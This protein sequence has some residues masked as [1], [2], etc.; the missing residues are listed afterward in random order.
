[1]SFQT[2]LLLATFA[3]PSYG[4]EDDVRIRPKVD[5]A[6]Q[7]GL[8]NWQRILPSELQGQFCSFG[9]S[10]RSF[11]VA[12]V[13]RQGVR[14]E[15]SQPFQP[16][17]LS[18]HIW[19][20]QLR[21]GL[22]GPVERLGGQIKE[23]KLEVAAKFRVQAPIAAAGSQPSLLVCLIMSTF[24]FLHQVGKRRC[25]LWG[26]EDGVKVPNKD[27]DK[28]KGSSKD[29]KVTKAHT[30]GFTSTPGGFCMYGVFLCILCICVYPIRLQHLSHS[31][32]T[33][34]ECASPSLKLKRVLAKEA[35][36]TVHQVNMWMSLQRW[37][38]SPSPSLSS[39]SPSPSPSSSLG[40]SPPLQAARP[41]GRD[42]RA[43]IHSGGYIL[44]CSQ[45]C[46][47]H[48]RRSAQIGY[49][50]WIMAS[51]FKGTFWEGISYSRGCSVTIAKVT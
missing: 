22:R 9:F 14:K 44:R 17:L 16:L 51:V 39:S 21:R 36:L 4:S 23:I 6:V 30:Q 40:R 32:L 50:C 35:G 46:T 1:M 42:H 37:S 26:G 3:Q 11:V 28:D 24:E 15:G 25:R 20:E 45:L 47:S 43:M 27:K 19:G 7:C 49:L 12:I 38:P 48:L 13:E 5:G 18:R 33:F 41:S 34:N 2:Y 8:S 29:K 31:Q 10:S